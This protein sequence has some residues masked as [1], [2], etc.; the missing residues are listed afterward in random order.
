MSDPTP[1]AA[2]SAPE[3]PINVTRL[4]AEAARASSVLWVE[5]HGRP[6][7]LWYVWHDDGDPRGTGPAAYIVVGE[8]EQH[9]PELPEEVSLIL[10]SKD[11]GGRLLRLNAAT[12]TLTA[13]SPGWEA[14]VAVLAPAR[15]NAP[16]GLEDRWRRGA[17]IVLLTPHG[18]PLAAPGDYS[19]SAQAATPT[20]SP[21]T[22]LSW[23][24]WHLGGRTRR[25]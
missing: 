18:A 8:G 2:A 25:R 5:V 4:L 3:A 13:H 15:L 20:A 16:P 12:R 6:Y 7:P 10:R 21:A 22:T 17:R 9:L 1:A 11:S 23:R 24:P 14:A 19:G